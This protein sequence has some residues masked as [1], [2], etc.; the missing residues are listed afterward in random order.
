MKKSSMLRAGLA[1]LLAAGAL[2]L[3]FGRNGP[4]GTG[5]PADAA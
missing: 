5:G 4:A 3:A 2:Y 1:G